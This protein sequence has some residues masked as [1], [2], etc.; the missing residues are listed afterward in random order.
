M[1]LNFP[2]KPKQSRSLINF[3][4]A[5]MSLAKMS[6]LQMLFILNLVFEYYQLLKLNWTVLP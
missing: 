1:S 2:S 6:L 3:G 5:M 4:L